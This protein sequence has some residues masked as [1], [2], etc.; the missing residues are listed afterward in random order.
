MK[1]DNGAAGVDAQTITDIPEYGEKR[2]LGELQAVLRKGEYKPQAVR[3][4]YI[5]K[6]DGRMRGLAFRRCVTGSY[7][8]RRR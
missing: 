4:C 7:T 2:L 5:P 1:R 6:T 8:R 3:R